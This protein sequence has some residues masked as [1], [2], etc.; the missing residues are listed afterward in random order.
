MLSISLC[1][2][3]YLHVGPMELLDLLARYFT[4]GRWS[5]A[6]PHFFAA[7]EG[8][9]AVLGRLN[10]ATCGSPGDVKGR[11]GG[12]KECETHTCIHVEI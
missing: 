12:H 6:E 5:E 1:L 7:L 10:P 3:L 2:C 9:R 8:R 4:W 11:I